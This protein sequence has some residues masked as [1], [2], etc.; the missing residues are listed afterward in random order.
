MQKENISIITITIIKKKLTLKKIQKLK[1]K[2]RNYLKK[3][4]DYK[5]MSCSN[6]ITSINYQYL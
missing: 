3:K 2:L 5:R 4:N 1:N 6:F